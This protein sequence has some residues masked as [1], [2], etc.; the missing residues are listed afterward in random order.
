MSVYDA[1]R[2]AKEVLE[3]NPRF[4]VCDMAFGTKSN[5]TT[6]LTKASHAKKAEAAEKPVLEQPAPARSSPAQ[7]GPFSRQQTQPQYW[8][9]RNSIAPSRISCSSTAAKI[10][11]PPRE[12]GCE[13]ARGRALRS[14]RTPLVSRGSRRE[15]RPHREKPLLVLPP[16][17][18]ARP[19]TRATRQ[20]SQ[21]EGSRS[22]I[23][24]F[25]G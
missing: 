25:P 17:V 18:A 19:P 2:A 16:P 10:H 5:L 4:D 3:R 13:A 6:H 7:R 15:S 1:G 8:I 21:A 12:N 20:P 9:A 23:S 24:S 14:Q 11:E 22:F